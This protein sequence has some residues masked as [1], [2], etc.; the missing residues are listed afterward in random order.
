MTE[1]FG[2]EKRMVCRSALEE[3]QTNEKR[4]IDTKKSFQEVRPHVRFSPKFLWTEPFHRNF[5]GL[6]GKIPI[7]F[8]SYK[9]ST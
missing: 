9:I 2:V 8:K 6:K 5:E 3:K 1:H 4:E 7:G